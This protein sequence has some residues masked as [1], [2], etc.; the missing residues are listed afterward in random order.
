MRYTS[1]FSIH[2][3]T[4]RNHVI[5]MIMMTMNTMVGASQ[6]RTAQK[7]NFERQF[8]FTLKK[9]LSYTQSFSILLYIWH[10]T[11]YAQFAQYGVFL[12]QTR[13][14]HHNK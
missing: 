3:I 2:N 14:Q 8:P 12:Q 13:V 7:A 11:H 9:I 10:P 1:Q 6:T 5:R 4:L